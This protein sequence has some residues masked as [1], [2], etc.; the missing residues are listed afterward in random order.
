MR[1]KTMQQPAAPVVFRATIAGDGPRAFRILDAFE[2]IGIGRVQGYAFIKNGELTT[3][4]IGRRRY[5]TAEA[6]TAFLERRI[7]ESNET[8]AQR[9][10]KVAA[11]TKARLRKR[12]K[13]A[14]A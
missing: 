2:R 14:A 12:T 13:C 1:S 11:A 5:A 7:A 6:I 3:F 9:A 8:A 4:L 10:G